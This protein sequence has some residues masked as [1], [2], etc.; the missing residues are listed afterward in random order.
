MSGVMKVYGSRLGL[1][2]QCKYGCCGNKLARCRK[3]T[4]MGRAAR[5][6]AKKR[7]RR[8]SKMP[9]ISDE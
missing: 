5:R 1:T 6:A 2:L 4:S 9:E 7:A 3:H 8:L